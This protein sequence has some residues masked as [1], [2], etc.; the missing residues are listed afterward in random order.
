MKWVTVSDNTL[1]VQERRSTDAGGR[2]DS[3]TPSFRDAITPAAVHE[4]V[5]DPRGLGS[6][7]MFPA[8]V[9]ARAA[10][11]AN[12]KA[13]ALIWIDP[14]GS[15]YP[16]AVMAGPV[17]IG[18]FDLVRPTTD[19]DTTWATVECLRCKQVAVVVS[20]IMHKLS[21][22]EVRRLQL[23]AESGGAAAIVMRPNLKSAAIDVY[24]AATRWHVSPAPGE[25][26]IQR[27]KIKQIHGHGRSDF[28][29]E[30][31]RATGQI[32]FVHPPAAM[33]RDPLLAQTS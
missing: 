31:N 25:R 22:V 27:W 32:D 5:F 14:A 18:E 6:P 24:A 20:L 11:D 9:A 19:D 30:K 8:L 23:A 12:D 16:P 33:A 26:T 3:R 10:I 13:K 28:L 4:L 17:P 1:H 2:S 15:L 21:R 29:L 7:P